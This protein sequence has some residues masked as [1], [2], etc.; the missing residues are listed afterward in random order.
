MV[1]GDCDY[2]WAFGGTAVTGL[3]EH[4]SAARHQIERLQSQPRRIDEEVLLEK[5]TH[6]EPSAMENDS[7]TEC[8]QVSKREIAREMGISRACKVHC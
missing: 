4:E 1:A 3:D 6:G 7:G 8:E 2:A 5:N